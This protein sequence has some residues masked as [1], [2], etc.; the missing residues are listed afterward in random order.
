METPTP[1]LASFTDRWASSKASMESMTI[2]MSSVYSRSWIQMLLYFHLLPAPHQVITKLHIILT[3][4]WGCSASAVAMMAS[5]KRLNRVG[6]STVL[7][8]TP[9]MMSSLPDILPYACLV[10]WCSINRMWTNLL[11]RWYISPLWNHPEGV[12]VDKVI[13]LPMVHKGQLEWGVLNSPVFSA[14]IYRKN[15]GHNQ[16]T[17]ALQGSRKIKF[18]WEA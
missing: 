13:C 15:L 2:A 6:A 3:S 1:E 9:V 16:H 10:P 18:V 4:K 17:H 7:G 11:G 5:K 14:C 12:T 8:L